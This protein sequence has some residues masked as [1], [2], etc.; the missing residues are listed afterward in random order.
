MSFPIPN[1]SYNLSK[2][3]Y[4]FYLISIVRE[5]IGKDFPT[6]TDIKRLLIKKGRSEEELQSARQLSRY[7]DTRS[8]FLKDA[9]EE[10]LEKVAK[11]INAEIQD[12]GLFRKNVSPGLKSYKDLE[13]YLKMAENYL[14]GL[15]GL[16]NASDGLLFGKLF[17]LKK[18][19]KAIINL[20][21]Y[22]FGEKDTNLPATHFAANSDTRTESLLKQL[23][24]FYGFHLPE[25]T[26][27]INISD[28]P[29]IQT[30][31]GI[32][33]FNNEISEW[34]NRQ[35]SFNDLI[36]IDKINACF[37]YYED[38]KPV[39][40]RANRESNEDYALI[41]RFIINPN[42]CVFLIGGIEGYGT[43]KIGEFFKNNW[44]KVY[45]LIEGYPDHKIVNLIFKISGVNGTEI[46]LIAIQKYKE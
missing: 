46:T 25:S 36:E 44:K 11:I 12:F 10:T 37:R 14:I 18:N 4:G 2:I 15:K 30:Y 45:H 32:G 28:N 19:G 21:S 31:I 24:T 40:L 1:T 13:V 27:G 8:T 6:E 20:I 3:G 34:V 7:C 23:F 17:H 26:S 29:E 9:R 42:K 5:L 43:E 33:Y 35:K 41:S 39:E 22:N 16:S 38:S